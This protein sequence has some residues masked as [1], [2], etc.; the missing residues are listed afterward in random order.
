MYLKTTA[1]HQQ[2]Q[3]QQQQQ[4]IV[5]MLMVVVVV[6]L[7]VWRTLHQ[8]YSY[9]HGDFRKSRRKTACNDDRP[10]CLV[11]PILRDEQ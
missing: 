6:L 10:Q 7:S 3:Q 9:Q 2:Q 4:R 11:S 5:L 1:T 8:T